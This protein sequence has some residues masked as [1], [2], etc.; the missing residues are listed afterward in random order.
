MGKKKGKKK[1]ETVNPDD[2]KDQGNL[3]FLENEFEKAIELYTKAIELCKDNPDKQH[4]ENRAKAR[5]SNKDFDL[6]IEDCD[7]IIQIDP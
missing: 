5:F 1:E 2:Y 3:A 6:C 7:S 4:F